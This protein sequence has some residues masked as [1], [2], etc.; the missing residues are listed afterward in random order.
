VKPAISVIIPAYNAA[1]TLPRALDI[2]D[3]ARHDRNAVTCHFHTYIGNARF[4][5]K[6]NA[7]GYVP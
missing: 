1:A 6:H 2:Q 7:M 3:A 4:I 5:D